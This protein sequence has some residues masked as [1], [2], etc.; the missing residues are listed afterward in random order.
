MRLR[1]GWTCVRSSNA[2]TIG[3]LGAA[4]A[5]AIWSTICSLCT[6]VAAETP[7]ALT[8]KDL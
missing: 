5:A 4:A 8:M 7:D 6:R 2:L 1:R 3:A